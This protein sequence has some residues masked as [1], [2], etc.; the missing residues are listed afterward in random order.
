MMRSGIIAV[1]FFGLGAGCLPPPPM[2]DDGCA[3][4]TDDGTSGPTSG[5]DTD[6]PLPTATET[7][8]PPGG[9]DTDG[10]SESDVGTESGDT[11]GEPP[12]HCPTIDA[13]YASR[14]EGHDVGNC[15]FDVSFGEAENFTPS[16]ITLHGG[17]N[18]NLLMSEPPAIGGLERLSGIIEWPSVASWN[19]LDPEGEGATVLQAG[20]AVFR[21]LV[22]W[23]DGPVGDADITGRSFYTVIADGRIMRDQYVHLTN[24]GAVDPAWLVDYTALRADYFT[25]LE[26]GG[27]ESGTYDVAANVGE[28]L[29]AYIYN[30]AETDVW[31]CAYSERSGDV[32]GMAPYRPADNEIIGPRASRSDA[33]AGNPGTASDSL[34]LQADWYRGAMLTTGIVRGSAMMFLEARTDNWCEGIEGQHAAYSA[35]TPI[36]SPSGSVPILNLI[37]D[38][39]GDGYSEGA[40]FYAFD[41]GSADTPIVLEVGSGPDIPTALL[42]IAGIGTL[43]VVSVSAGEQI[44]REGE[45]L[46]QDAIP[47]AHWDLVPD[48]EPDFPAGLYVLLA[49]PVGTGDQI[50]IELN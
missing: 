13:L 28:A 12:G 3:Q 19:G 17:I 18:D 45:Y 11:T 22:E 9:T 26:W 23:H 33:D 4:A 16:R 39:D 32:V 29:A 38:D 48:P 8:G 14:S 5:P 7:E 36:T 47:E 25:A 35:A 31:L 37:G 44:L 43:D 27:E 34:A 49:D 2:C 20:P 30:E 6:G 40:G 42:F 10:G 24:M 50:T 1:G 41:A 46:L 21:I 15:S